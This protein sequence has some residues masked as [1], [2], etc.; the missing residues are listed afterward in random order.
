MSDLF[1]MKSVKIDDKIC[2]EFLLLLHVFNATHSSVFFT[3]LMFYLSSGVSFL[4][5]ICTIFFSSLH[6]VFRFFFCSFRATICLP[7]LTFGPRPLGLPAQT[8]FLP[9]LHF[10]RWMIDHNPVVVVCC[11]PTGRTCPGM[12]FPVVVSVSEK[13]V[14]SQFMRMLLVF[15]ANTSLFY[16]FIITEF[17]S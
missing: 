17:P 11:W 4:S 2:G 3:W 14:C 9:S 12:S 5:I 6:F 1:A 10:I 8:G 16:C 7:W 15:G 13:L